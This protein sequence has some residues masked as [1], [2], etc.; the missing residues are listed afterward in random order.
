[1]EFLRLRSIT[2]L[3][4]FLRMHTNN[5]PILYIISIRFGFY[6]HR[7]IVSIPF[8]PEQN[9]TIIIST[10]IGYILDEFFS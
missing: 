4:E 3:D 7:N 9:I 1:M 2:V 6:L 5:A 8:I 10:S